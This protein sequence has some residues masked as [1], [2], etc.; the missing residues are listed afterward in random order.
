MIIEKI[1]RKI[2]TQFA[3]LER[4]EE[5][6][7]FKITTQ[8]KILERDISKILAKNKDTEL[9][10]YASYIEQRLDTIRDKK[11]EG[12]EMM[13]RNKLENEIVDEWFKITNEITNEKMERHQELVDQLTGCLEGLCQKKEAEI[14]KEEDGMQE[15]RLK[16]RMGEEFKIEEMQLKIKK[17]E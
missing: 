1:K 4:N 2:T 14:R 3:I 17:E 8:F 16:R 5:K 15:Q 11:Y 7:T 13:I 6:I 9:Q 12:Q 10:K